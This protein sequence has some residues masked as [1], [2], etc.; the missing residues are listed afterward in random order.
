MSSA[1]PKVHLSRDKKTLEAKL[2]VPLPTQIAKYRPE[3]M[4]GADSH[5]HHAYPLQALQVGDY[6]YMVCVEER[7]EGAMTD[8]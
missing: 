5:I 1:K 4:H 6:C 2:L 8:G 7:Q 3:V